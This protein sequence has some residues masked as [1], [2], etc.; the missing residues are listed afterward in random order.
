MLMLLPMSKI[1]T[2]L[3]RMTSPRPAPDEE[4]LASEFG[5]DPELMVALKHCLALADTALDNQQVEPNRHT[6]KSESEAA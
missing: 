6:P 1:P 2:R 3:I 5:D 4:T